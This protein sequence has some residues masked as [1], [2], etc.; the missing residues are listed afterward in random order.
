MFLQY[1]N[2]SINLSTIPKMIMTP[3]NCKETLTLSPNGIEN[4]PIIHKSASNIA[5]RV[6]RLV[7]FTI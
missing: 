3:K 4:I 7:M 1:K 6:I 2:L 5:S